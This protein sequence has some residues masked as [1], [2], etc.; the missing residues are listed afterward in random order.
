MNDDEATVPSRLEV[1]LGA[2]LIPFVLAWDLLKAVRLGLL[3]ALLSLT[4]GLRQLVR[5]L[6]TAIGRVLVV[7][8]RWIRQALVAVG[9]WVGGAVRALGRVLV[10]PMRWARQALVAVGRWVGG[11]LRAL[12]RALVVPMRSAKQ[13]MKTAGVLI[14]S[15]LQAVRRLVRIPYRWAAKILSNI[16]A[17]T[18]RPVRAIGR[19]TRRL[20]EHLRARGKRAAASVAR[21]K[22]RLRSAVPRPH[23]RSKRP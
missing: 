19:G 10:V 2:P 9:G 11:A 13:A 4:A 16:G 1:V 22:S 23:I 7:P 6:F 20:T 17:T 15:G 18:L 21:Q 12:R 3:R 5:V 8:M 14:A